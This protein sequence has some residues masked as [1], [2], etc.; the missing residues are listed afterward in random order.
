M[1]TPKH[2]FFQRA[3]RIPFTPFVL[4]SWSFSPNQVSPVDIDH[5]NTLA[6]EKHIGVLL[7]QGHTTPFGELTNGCK[8]DKRSLGEKKSQSNQI[9]STKDVR[10]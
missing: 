6:V 3:V 7:Q 2:L 4:V 9:H 5:I 8:K 10:F 1:K